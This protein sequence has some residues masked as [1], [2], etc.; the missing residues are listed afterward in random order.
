[1]LSVCEIPPTAVGRNH[2]FVSQSACIIMH[3]AARV[4]GGAQQQY[5][6]V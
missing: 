6:E 4:E 3:P 5:R 1:M 2:Y